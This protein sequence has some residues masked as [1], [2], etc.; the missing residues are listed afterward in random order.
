MVVLTRSYI[1]TEGLSYTGVVQNAKHVRLFPLPQELRSAQRSCII[2]RGCC[3]NTDV[4]HQQRLTNH[5]SK[6]VKRLAG[7]IYIYI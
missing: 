7:Y 1:V 6:W 4:P 2:N 5:P 3:T